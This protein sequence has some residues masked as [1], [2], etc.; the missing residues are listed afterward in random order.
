M[1]LA[2]IKHQLFFL[3]VTLS[4]EIWVGSF[5]SHF[6]H[7]HNVRSTYSNRAP[8]F[9]ICTYPNSIYFSIFD[10]INDI[11]IKGIDVISSD[12]QLVGFNLADTIIKS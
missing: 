7:I 11:F 10:F 8:S 2:V 9:S 12:K 4:C 1:N 5:D 3:S 6:W